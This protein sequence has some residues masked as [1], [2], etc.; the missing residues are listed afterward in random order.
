MTAT[1]PKVVAT[2]RLV[3][4][5]EKQLEDV[6]QDYQWRR[7]PELAVYDAA[8][9]LSM[10]YDAFVSTVRGELES[11]ASHRRPY[12]IEELDGGKHIGNVMYYGHDPGLQEAELGVTIGDRAYW[13]R[14]YGSDAVRAVL[15]YLFRELGLRRVYLHTLTWNDRAQHAF[16]RAGL[17]PVREVKRGGYDF[18]L[19]EILRDEFA[20]Q[21]R[22]RMKARLDAEG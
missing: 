12:A 8:Q 4:L 22:T 10:S 5:R 16:S 20:E 6:Q 11:P 2:G 9:P 13:S 3:R 19:M 15:G 17:R 1:A 18:V 14:G 21:E 7:D